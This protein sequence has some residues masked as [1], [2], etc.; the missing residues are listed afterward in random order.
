MVGCMSARVVATFAIAALACAGAAAAQDVMPPEGRAALLEKAQR[1][2]AEALRPYEPDRVENALN[3]VEKIL[4]R[5]I[6]LH[7]FFDSAY[8][9]GGFTLGAGYIRHLSDY[10]TLDV[11]A[12][13][14]F[15]GYKRIE[16]EFLA[17]RLF[18]RRGTLSVIGGW[19]EA[20]AVG[21]YGLGTENTSVN[22]RA[23]YAFDQPYGSAVFDFWPARKY[24]LLR[25]GVDLSTWNTA[26]GNGP[27]LPVDD[28]YTAATLP[29]LGGSPTYLHSEA[30]VGIDTRTSPGY[31]RRGSY[32]GATFHD[33]HD[34]N[35]DFGFRQSDYEA[36]QHVP[37]LKETW[38]L[39]LHGRVQMATSADGQ[40]VPYFMMPALGGGSSL[41]GFSSWRFRDLNS[42]LLQAEWRVIGSRIVDM[43][44][45]YDAGRVTSRRSD[46]FDGHLK[47]DY[48]VGFRV[49]G[50]YA[51]PLR[52]ELAHGNEGLSLVFSAKAPF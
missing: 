42:L 51:T 35:G 3:K 26:P 28:V 1:D 49:H 36:I 18:N 45:F 12:S 17:P 24:L 48:G 30:T 9:G 4:L 39:S 43:A 32:L 27:E 2:K 10:N 23:N 7:P 25:G 29:G 21:F 46:L 8:S 52:L 41:R 37:F 44:L 50:R 15:S 22:D 47:S 31:T 20:T 5:G 11:R 40:A 19:R 16:A 33:Y 6:R 38:V 13:F 34:A 14:T